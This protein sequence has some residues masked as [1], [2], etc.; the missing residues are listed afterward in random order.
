VDGD[1]TPDVIFEEADP[2]IGGLRTSRQIRKTSPTTLDNTHKITNLKTGIKKEIKA[3]TKN[4][5]TKG[6]FGRLLHTARGTGT[7]FN[8]QAYSQAPYRSRRDSYN[9]AWG[10]HVYRYK[11]R[12]NAQGPMLCSKCNQILET[13]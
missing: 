12:H 5:L 3:T 2:L 1:A 13:R 7:D 10:P 9:V 4:I 8:I 6:V 11:K